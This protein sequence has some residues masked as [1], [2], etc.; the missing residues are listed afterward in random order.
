MCNAPQ[1]ADVAKTLDAMS[2]LWYYHLCQHPRVCRPDRGGNKSAAASQGSNPQTVDGAV[3]SS[4][5]DS[6]SLH[7]S[8]TWRQLVVH[9][10]PQCPV[11]SLKPSVQRMHQRTRSPRH[12]PKP[13]RGLAAALR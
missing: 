3:A 1:K 4:S 9:P 10:L 11:P 2:H 13:R 12:P 7:K 6:L 5:H 8:H